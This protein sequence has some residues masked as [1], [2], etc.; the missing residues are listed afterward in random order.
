MSGRRQQASKRQRPRVRKDRR[1]KRRRNDEVSRKY[2]VRGRRACGRKRRYRTREEAEVV[3][4]ESLRKGSDESLRAYHCP[5][6][7]GWHLT[8]LV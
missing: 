7:K 3:A 1:E 4:L 5:Y 8:H 6:C 2:G